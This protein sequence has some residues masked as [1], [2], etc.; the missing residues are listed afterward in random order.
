[1][2]WRANSNILGLV[3]TNAQLV[4]RSLWAIRRSDDLIRSLQQ[5]LIGIPSNAPREEAL[6]QANHHTVP[7]HE[8][9]VSSCRRPSRIQAHPGIAESRRPAVSWASN[10]AAPGAE[11]DRMARGNGVKIR[12]L[13]LRRDFPRSGE[14]HDRV[15]EE[16]IV[17]LRSALQESPQTAMHLRGTEVLQQE[18]TTIASRSDSAFSKARNA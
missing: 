5:G 4:A 2:S 12:D 11:H 1:M 14:R 6:T 3:E 13:D 8:L 10:R 15:V 9:P 17:R 16:E 7:S 18:G